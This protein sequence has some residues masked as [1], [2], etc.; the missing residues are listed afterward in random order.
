[1]GYGSLGKNSVVNYPRMAFVDDFQA[2][3]SKE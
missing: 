3:T 1:M 2:A